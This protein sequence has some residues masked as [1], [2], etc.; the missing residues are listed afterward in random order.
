MQFISRR[1]KRLCN[2]CDDG[3]CG[4]NSVAG[5]GCCPDTEHTIT[6]LQ[7]PRPSKTL[8]ASLTNAIFSPL[9]LCLIETTLRLQL[10]FIFEIILSYVCRV[11]F[12]LFYVFIQQSK[13]ETRQQA[14]KS[15]FLT[16]TAAVG[17]FCVGVYSEK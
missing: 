16:L 5:A 2:D 17:T 9:Y 3:S 6:W 10:D 7:M 13:K 4:G 14:H 1:E 12:V 11:I 15:A 8:V